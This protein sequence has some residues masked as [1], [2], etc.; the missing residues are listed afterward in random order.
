[1]PSIE[2]EGGFESFRTHTSI[3]SVNFVTGDSQSSSSVTV[4]P[5]GSSW[6]FYKEWNRTPNFKVLARQGKL[7]D[8][9]FAMDKWRML[10]YT[11][12][13]AVKVGRSSES[14]SVTRRTVTPRLPAMGFGEPYGN[15]WPGV[16]AGLDNKAVSALLS[17]AKGNQWN[18]PV[19]V[20]EGRKTAQM[21]YTRATQI[22]FAIRALRKGR[23]DV[24]LD[25]LH[26][27]DRRDSKHRKARRTFNSDFGRD[28]FRAVSNMW[29]EYTYGWTPFM[30]DVRSAAFALMDAVEKEPNREARFVGSAKSAQRVFNPSVRWEVFPESTGPYFADIKDSVRYVWRAAPNDLDLPARF[31]L[32]NP[33]EIGWE[34]LPFSFV[35]DWFLPIGDYLSALDVP[36]RFAHKGGTRGFL[37]QV[38]QSGFANQSGWW[39]TVEGEFASEFLRV[40]RSPLREPPSIDLLDF[41]LDPSIGAKKA[42]T[43][44][45][46]L[47][48]Q[49]S[50]LG[51]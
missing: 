17:K 18:A 12:H 21:V 20:M 30:S 24:F 22:V 3:N 47:R 37:R 9:N 43:A 5:R 35:A 40:R 10:H 13:K 32:A 4:G 41:E 31:G 51:T 23:F 7:P 39:T 46:L 1:M 26:K 44:I 6:A 8:N 36:Y 11:A 25:N 28:P 38:K 49:A 50:R 2:T 33:F 42:I 45:A 15:A 27:V 16:P 14:Y 29:L 48:Q 34:L 19:F